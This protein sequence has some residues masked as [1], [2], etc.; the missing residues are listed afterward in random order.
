[1]F[2]PHWIRLPRR[3]RRLLGAKVV[4]RLV[5][6]DDGMAA[7]EFAMVAAPFFALLFAIIEMCFVFF[8]GQTLETVTADTARLIMTGQAQTAGFS[9]TQFKQSLCS[10]VFALFDCTNKIKI[11]VRTASS[12]GAADMSSPV[13]A[14]KNL[15]NNQVYNPGSAGSIVVVRVMY[16]WPVYVKLMGLN[17]ADL[18]NGKRLVM[19][20][21][22]FRNE[23]YQ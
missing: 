16:E 18:A 3:L 4:R 15:M 9:E 14:N 17:M 1:M 21:A 13:D 6:R 8:A 23:P 20:T 2:H 5:R 7:V 11:D 12:F 10:R 19:A 22:V